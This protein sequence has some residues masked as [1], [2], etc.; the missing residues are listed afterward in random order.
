MEYPESLETSRVPRRWVVKARSVNQ[1]A[2]AAAVA[3]LAMAASGPAQAAGNTKSAD[4]EWAMGRPV[5]DNAV[6]SMRSTYSRPTLLVVQSAC[7]WEKAMESLSGSLAY[8][9]DQMPEVDWAHQAVVVVALGQVPYGYNLKVNEVRLGQGKLMLDLHV[10]YQSYQNSLDDVSPAAVVVVDAS[11]PK[12]RALYD[13]DLPGLP[14]QADAPKCGLSSAD[15]TASNGDTD[16]RPSVT[17]TWGAL[18]SLYR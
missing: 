2:A 17:G 16:P 8:G 10:D 9:A 7:Q 12:V 11:A 18:K 14:H 4:L 13:L 6:A 3:L 15:Q 5:A 1:T